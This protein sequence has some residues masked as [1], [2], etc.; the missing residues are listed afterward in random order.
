MTYR[1]DYSIIALTHQAWWWGRISLCAFT[2][3]ITRVHVHNMISTKHNNL[4]CH[5]THPHK[6]QEWKAWW[7]VWKNLSECMTCKRFNMLVRI[8]CLLMVRTLSIP[9]SILSNFV[10]TSSMHAHENPT[11]EHSRVFRNWTKPSYTARLK[12]S[13]GLLWVFS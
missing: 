12:H 9:P 4:C 2:S 1:K 11:H 5:N 6:Q 13:I 3:H 8:C 10:K 7:Y